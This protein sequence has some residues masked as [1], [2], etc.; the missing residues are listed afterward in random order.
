M[1]SSFKGKLS[2]GLSTLQTASPP[3]AGTAS[4]VADAHPGAAADDHDNSNNNNNNNASLPPPPPSTP[5]SH[6]PTLAPTSNVQGSFGSIASRFSSSASS[7]AL[8]FRRPLKATQSRSSTDLLP[9]GFGVASKNGASPFRQD[10]SNSAKSLVTLVQQLTMDPQNE[11]PDPA[12]V[13]RIREQYRRPQGK[14]EDSTL[15]D[16]QDLEQLLQFPQDGSHKE[17]RDQQP[18]QQPQQ[19]Q[20]QQPAGTELSEAV[21][22]KL[23]ILQR[24][25]ARFPGEKKNKKELRRE[26]SSRNSG[27]I[28]IDRNANTK[29]DRERRDL[30]SAF[31]RIVQEKLAAEA[32]LRAA[33]PLEDLGDVEALE[34]HLQNLAHKSQM[35]MKEIGRLSEELREAKTAK[36]TEL[37]SQS[38][39]IE[40]LNDQI[41]EQLQEIERLRG[42]D[43][44]TED[45]YRS[46]TVLTLVEGRVSDVETKVNS[47]DLASPSLS[48]EDTSSSLLE[49][50]ETATGSNN[51]NNNNNTLSPHTSS[52]P[53]SIQKDKKPKD[54]LKK[55]QA[56]RELML[57]LEN[58]L[59][60]KNQAQEEQEEA[61]E[62]AKFLREKL[63]KE[64]KVNQ[65]MAEKMDRLQ[66]LVAEMEDREHRA[67]AAK[68]HKEPEHDD[69]VDEI[70]FAIGADDEGSDTTPLVIP[71]QL[72]RVQSDLESSLKRE[73]EAVKSKQETEATL[74]ALRSTH[75]ALQE[76]MEATQT[77]L[78]CA[79]GRVS[80]LQDLAVALG[81][82]KQDLMDALEEVKE[83]QR[84][85][86]L[87]RLWR[88]EAE[89]NRDALKREHEISM[90]SWKT[91]ME[92]A[93]RDVLDLRRQLDQDI[94][95]T[96]AATSKAGSHID[97]EVSELQDVIRRMEEQLATVQREH[98]LH[99][100][101]IKT[102]SSDRDCMATVAAEHQAAVAVLKTEKDEVSTALAHLQEQKHRLDSRIQ[103]L[104]S[105]LSSRKATQDIAMDGVIIPPAAT[106]PSKDMETLRARIA[107]QES[108]IEQK[109]QR[110][111]EH[112]HRLQEEMRRQA[113]LWSRIQELEVNVEKPTTLRRSASQGA[114]RYRNTI[115]TFSDMLEADNKP[116]LEE[117]GFL[118]KERA[119]LSEKLTRLERLHQGFERSSSERIEGLEKELTLLLQQ[120]VALEVQVQEQSVLLIKEKEE[121]AK[122][123]ESEVE[124]EQ[125][126]VAE[127]IE[128]VRLELEAVR[129]AERFASSKVTELA[130]DRDEVIEKVAKLESRL[131]TLN[132]CKAGQEQSLTG[133]IEELVGEK[134]TLEKQI[135]DLNADL[136]QLRRQGEKEKEELKL[137]IEKSEMLDSERKQARARILELEMKLCAIEAKSGAENIKTQE[138]EG[139][140]STVQLE[141]QAVTKKLAI[142]QE[143]TLV[144]RTLHED[145]VATLTSQVESFKIERD[146]LMQ[147]KQELESQVQE[148]TLRAEKLQ[149]QLCV[150]EQDNERMLNAKTKAQEEVTE[151]Q[152]RIHLLEA[153]E[154][155]HKEALALTKDTMHQRDEDLS[156]TQ[157]LLKQAETKLEKALAKVTKL[158]KE[159]RSRKEEVDSLKAAM[160]TAKQEAKTQISQLTSQHSATTTEL[161]K[162]KAGHVKAIQERDQ[163]AEDRDRLNQDR[164]ARQKEMQMKQAEF[165]TLKQMNDHAEVQLREY[166]A[167]LT[168]AR[169]RADT[170]EELTSIAKRVAETK[171]T[172]FE[173]LKRRSQGLEEELAVARGQIQKDEEKLQEL[174]R[175]WKADVGDSQ[176]EISR[177][178]AAVD[179]AKDEVEALH[180]KE[181]ESATA[182]T[183]LRIRLDEQ[184]QAME[185]L[186]SEALELKGEKRNLA[187]EVQHFKDLEEILANEKAAHASA[188]EELKMRE[189][190]LRT[191]N[192]GLKDEV[193]KLQKYAPNS[194]LPSPA[195]PYPPYSQQQGGSVPPPPSPG[196]GGSQQPGLYHTPSTPKPKSLASSSSNNGGRAFSTPAMSLTPPSTPR[197]SRVAQQQDGDGE[198]DVNVEYLKNVLLNFMEHKD[199]RQQLIPVVAQMLRLSSEET[200]RFS[201]VV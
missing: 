76:T 72:L 7:S 69:I 112:Q 148:A 93:G 46:E 186:Q 19:Q 12:A 145:K 41:A 95:R 29:K 171:V 160:S 84:L 34:A 114:A 35:S 192:K 67:M 201:K 131:E 101:Q 187:L 16:K 102:L 38:K 158:E 182:F 111:S 90:S 127:G 179:Q 116:S 32:V 176:E 128:R 124:V 168:E 195:T 188:I 163:V 161:Q 45:G 197:F 157:K 56:L 136:D 104:E 175:Q 129:T 9:S 149:Q 59:K 74:S 126:R 123:K 98:D 177:L 155:D 121:K 50:S 61:V 143:Q 5:L 51:N 153:K 20:Q 156:A 73:T 43:G 58:V 48:H 113:G 92:Q 200:R 57:R 193:R 75:I 183:E 22:E 25:E 191:L 140:L 42:L 11:K 105:E 6:A 70:M 21:L 106:P 110:V 134:E 2:T 3:V 18:D 120:K 142:A 117:L 132:E 39:M 194:P 174:T 135:G 151:L 146:S 190:H 63:E 83:K 166:Q 77:E 109:D 118:K 133:R 14:Q 82:T 26:S 40:D 94:E 125:A 138:L 162:L 172:E 81:E 60:E 55:D 130:K 108:V 147:P 80:D 144:Q 47:L 198:N 154:R 10:E 89:K 184:E 181:V 68:K 99:L 96:A 13:D 78:E 33:T 169:N 141:L 31:K 65:E 115:S 122:E 164:E 30:A 150:L 71:E 15:G 37:A 66:G 180:T 62:E 36:E 137:L 23:E 4:A 173:D 170:L 53:A 87:E 27:S 17:P 44:T 119:E 8:F 196:L 139:S 167:Q 97:I 189:G 24:Y 91:E 79:N 178:T 107:E 28:R 86:D 103:E 159:A 52:T 49:R 152:S 1:F 199:R 100:Q 88:E 165:E 85:L 64:G 185:A 54:S